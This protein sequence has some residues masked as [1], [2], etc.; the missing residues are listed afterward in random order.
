VHSTTFSNLPPGKYTFEVVTGGAHG[1][2]AGD[3][4]RLDIIVLAPWW[5]TYWAYSF[6]ALLLLLGAWQAYR[7][8]IRRIQLQEQLAFEHREAERIRA[9]EQMKSDFFSNITH[10]LRT[11][12]TLILEPLRQVLQNPAAENWLSKV[13][14]AESNSHK[15]L[16]LVNQ[17]LDLAKLEGGAMHPEY[18]RG[19]VNDLLLALA[20]TFAEKARN[21]KI[22]FSSHFPDLE[23]FDFDSDKLEKI[24]GNLL[25]NAFKFTPEGGAVVMHW[26]TTPEKWFVLEVSDS[27][28]G[29]AA[30]DL[31]KVFDRFYSKVKGAEQEQTSTGIGLALC[32]ELA[33]LMGG[34]MEV[35][36]IPGKH[37][38]FRLWLPVQNQSNGATVP[39][40]NTSEEA[41][42]SGVAAPAPLTDNTV[43]A[44]EKNNRPLLLL[45][46]DN[47]EL[48]HFVSQTLQERYDVL[49]AP[50]GQAAVEMA[51]ERIPDII[52]S[53]LMMPRLDGLGLLQV[54]KNDVRTSHIPMVLLTA[55]MALENRIEGLQHGADAYL[56]KP[57]QTQELFAWLENLLESRRRLQERFTQPNTVQGTSAAPADNTVGGPSTQEAKMGVLDQQFLDRLRDITE[58]EIDN[59]QVTPELLARGMNMSRSQLHRKLS[60]LTGLS[61]TEYVRNYRLDR[62][63]EL[64]QAG[65]GNVSEIAFRVGFVNA[66]HFSTSFKERF[67]KSP[68]EV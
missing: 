38:M 24:A 39:T 32:R 54:L 65:A 51:F 6:Y 40:P 19:Q 45:A 59:D 36:S 53:D 56:G 31:P 44:A 60:A 18:R 29:I 2:W 14:L 37:T 22:E 46:E 16:Q 35:E 58:Q 62:A 52:V 10:E 30:E 43:E 67:G 28:T 21:K 27:G 3:P 11:P 9:I 20:G 48:R 15:L 61:A 49:Q 4:T 50:D 55:K 7:I 1:M 12:V 64:L 57:F 66:K 25:S 13:Q 5:R 47:D 26:Y 17:L 63:L 68:S 42:D 34:R 8:Q 41:A 23:P 33:E